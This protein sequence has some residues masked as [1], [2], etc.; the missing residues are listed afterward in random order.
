[1][2]DPLPRVPFAPWAQARRLLRHP[3]APFW[4]AGILLATGALYGGVL[5]GVQVAVGAAIRGI[6]VDRIPRGVLVLGNV[7]GG[8]AV[9]MVVHGGGTLIVWL[10]CRAVGGPGGLGLLYRATA[11]VL[12]WGLPALPALAF[13]T[14]V[15]G[16]APLP[17]GLL[18]GAVAGAV[19]V[20]LALYHTIR[21]T[22]GLSPL[23][24]AAAT[25]LTLLF[26][27]SIALL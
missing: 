19:L 11:F 5:S 26:S 4:A 25:F 10:M 13:R 24:A 2:T 23:R 22:Q 17:P 18:A 8:V 12:P 1:M 21:A 14:A 9:V 3:S 15:Q 6:P 7:L 27:G 20:V 16:A